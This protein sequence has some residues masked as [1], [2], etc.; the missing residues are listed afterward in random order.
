MDLT[1]EEIE[2]INNLRRQKKELKTGDIVKRIT[3]IE[4]KYVIEEIRDDDRMIL[5]ELKKGKPTRRNIIGK[6][7][8]YAKV[9]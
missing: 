1:P 9:E 6:L 7:Y 2:L 3:P 8:N 4:T 5:R